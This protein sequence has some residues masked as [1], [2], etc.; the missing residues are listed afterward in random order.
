MGK[1]MANDKRKMLKCICDY[2][3]C[4]LSDTENFEWAYG[5][6]E[7]ASYYSFDYAGHRYIAGTGDACVEIVDNYLSVNLNIGLFEFTTAEEEWIA[8]HLSR[9]EHEAISETLWDMVSSRYYDEDPIE[10]VSAGYIDEADV[11]ENGEFIGDYDLYESLYDFA[12]DEYEMLIDDNGTVLEAYLDY[13][14]ESIAYLVDEGVITF[15]VDDLAR[16]IV[17]YE[18]SADSPIHRESL[19][20]YKD[21]LRPELSDGEI[22][23]LYETSRH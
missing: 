21:E 7:Y 6:S 2:F 17:D 10:L 22:Y 20:I 9:R 12:H 23:F 19:G 3:N 14:G 18:N 1:I 13:T 8:N 16:F 4:D 11:D 5:V 15:D